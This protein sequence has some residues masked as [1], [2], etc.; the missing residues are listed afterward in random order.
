MTKY[1]LALQDFE[2]PQIKETDEIIHELKSYE[3]MIEE[4]ELRVKS[5]K[6]EV[7]E[8]LKDNN[9]YKSDKYIVELKTV[10]QNRMNQDLMKKFIEEKGGDLT[11]FVTPSSHQRLNIK[12]LG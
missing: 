6:G 10:T 7:S 12:V 4:L 9:L 8:R 5:I 11:L 1:L 3:R 2:N